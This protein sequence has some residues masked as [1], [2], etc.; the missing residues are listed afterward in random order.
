VAAHSA[1]ALLRLPVRL[2]GVDLGRAVDLILDPEGRRAIGIDVLYKDDG[3]R[4]LPL[5]A[6]QIDADHIAVA[7]ALVLLAADE[8]AFYRKRASTMRLL[9]GAPVRRD[10]RE[11][12][13]LRDVLVGSGGAVEHLVTEDGRRIT[14]GEDVRIT[15]EPRSVDAA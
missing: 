8:L 10:G 9:R 1:E 15:A 3:H 6:A 4:F 11:V 5:S 12:G 2:R 7:S 14:F 13:R